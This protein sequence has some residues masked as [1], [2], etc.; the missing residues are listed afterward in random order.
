MTE[1][2]QAR[3]S[4]LP[5]AELLQYLRDFHGYRAEAVEAA[6]VELDRRGLAFSEAERAEIRRGLE[7]RDAAAEARLKRGFVAGLGPT[8]ATRL[9]RIRQLTTGLLALGLGS[10]AAIYL[11]AAQP[12]SNPLGYEP[13][14]TKKYLRD[15][16]L[17]G[18]KVN[19]LA[20]E[21][22]KWWDGLWH[23]RNLASTVAWLT[24][25]LAL[26]FWFTATRRARHLER[27]EEDGGR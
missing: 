18:G 11:L 4:G 9:A 10:A 16:E 6:L 5:D 3:I 14:D 22:T 21:F 25:L 13:E 12:G 17:Y 26:A 15:L 8:T 2:F 23:G 7:A 27:L 24:I 1:T 19:V 20:T